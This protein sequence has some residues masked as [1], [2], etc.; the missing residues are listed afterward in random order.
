[1]P[2]D[3]QLIRAKLYM[4]YIDNYTQ[5]IATNQNGSSHS[6]HRPISCTSPRKL[7]RESSQSSH[8]TL[9]SSTYSAPSAR[10]DVLPSSATVLENYL[11]RI[12]LE[13][14]RSGQSDAQRREA[15]AKIEAI[16]IGLSGLLLADRTESASWLQLMQEGRVQKAM[17]TARRHLEETGEDVE[18]A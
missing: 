14:A 13:L 3:R 17:E 1:M 5:P 9:S 12:P 8:S 4:Y 11:P 15:V 7:A 10:Q 6:S 16:K 18:M 2:P